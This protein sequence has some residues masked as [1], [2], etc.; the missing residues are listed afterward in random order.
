MAIAVQSTHTGGGTTTASATVTGVTGGTDQVYVVGVGTDDNVDV[1]S[2][3]GGGLTWVEEVEQ[4][5]G[6]NFQGMRVFRAIGS[7]S[8]FTLT[9][10]LG[11]TADSVAIIVVRLSGVDQAS[12]IDDAQGENTIGANDVVC[13][14]GI[15]NGNPTLTL[16]SILDAS[17]HINFVASRNRDV[18]AAPNYTEEDAVAFGAGANETTVHAHTRV[19]NPAA[20]DQASFT[21]TD[22][23]DWAFAGVVLAPEPVDAQA[24]INAQSTVASNGVLNLAGDASVAGQ[25]SVVANGISGLVGTASIA[26][27]SLV[28]PIGVLDIIGSAIIAGQSA[29]SANGTVI[30]FRNIGFEQVGSIPGEANFWTFDSLAS[31]DDIAEFDSI[32]P[33]TVED[34]EEEWDS[35]EDYLFTLGPGTT[36]GALFDQAIDPEGQEDFEEGWSQ[37]ELYIF[38]LASIEQAD[39][40]TDG[41]LEFES[42]ETDWQGNNSYLFTFAPI[43][44]AVGQFDTTPQDFE[45]FEEEWA[46]NENYLFAFGGGDVSVASF[47]SGGTP[48]DFED[49]E[50]LWTLTMTTL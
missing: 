23:P 33:E 42:F 38:Q 40:N 5:S 9:V 11:A 15:D 6:R 29:V 20:A 39:L 43:D 44:V 26:G 13:L 4:C 3:S 36:L 18:I 32:L 22:S 35:N 24:S 37:N 50:E 1:T 16:T 8:G 34:F 27:Q 28:A 2:L 47:D 19:L 48:E 45:D 41:F 31:I 49:F 7:P 25:S 46:G 10:T 21:V 12:P 30:A 17:M 14:G